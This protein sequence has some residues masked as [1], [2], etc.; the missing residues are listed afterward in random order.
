MRN[1]SF[2]APAL[3][4][5]AA[6][7]PQSLA[8]S[9]APTD[10]YRQHHTVEAPAIDEREFRPGW[11]VKTKLMLL[12]ETGRIDRRQFEA[13]AAFKGWC[14]AVGRQRTST[15]LAVRVDGG[16]R[17]EG[18]IS[19]HQIDSARRLHDA[20]MALG[21]DRV[22]LLFWVIV[23]DLAWNRLG[24]RLGVSTKTATWRAVEAIDALALWRAGELVPPAP[25]IRP[26][27]E[28]GRW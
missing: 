21:R 22:K 4:P 19:T 8:F 6:V 25:V 16:R 23:D 26:R 7:A 2:S 15:W 3:S 1:K 24:P 17:P 20:G 9:N 28:P 27:I 11:R 5:T 18:L 10:F 13:A 14:E 12:L